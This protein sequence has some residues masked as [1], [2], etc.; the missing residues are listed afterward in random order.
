MS[1]RGIGD[2]VCGVAVRPSLCGGSSGVEISF[3]S[4][5]AGKGFFFKSVNSFGRRV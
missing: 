4:R 5:S 3:H 1:G 2:T